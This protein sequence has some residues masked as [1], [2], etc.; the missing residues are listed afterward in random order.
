LIGC[1]LHRPELF[2]A[3]LPSGRS[4]DEAV[5]PAE[6]VGPQVRTLYERIYAPLADG[7]PVALQTLLSELAEGELLGLANLATDAYALIEN[8]SGGDGEVIGDTLVK[9][10]E[11]IAAYHGGREY[12]QMRKEALQP[13]DVAENQDLH[14]RRIQ[15]HNRSHPSP[16]RFPQMKH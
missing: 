15:E 2:H 7:R 11:Y 14:L 9:A 13:Q 1:L 16:V 6:L 8:H 3:A 4:L 12:Q 5:S 10:A